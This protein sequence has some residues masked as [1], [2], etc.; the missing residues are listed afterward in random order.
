MEALWSTD[1]P[2][3][4]DNQDILFC[5]RPNP[6]ETF[7]LQRQYIWKSRVENTV[8]WAMRRKDSNAYNGKVRAIESLRTYI[9]E[10]IRKKSLKNTLNDQNRTV[11]TSILH[12][13]IWKKDSHKLT[14]SWGINFLEWS[15]V[16]A[17]DW[18]K[19]VSNIFEYCLA[20]EYKLCDQ[21]LGRTTW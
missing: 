7:R 5:E 6:K 13:I 3:V 12:Y 2:E 21:Y 8:C 18:A 9:L 1:Q 20:W 14:R 19:A 17:K 16:F 10:D 4:I 11:M 15:C